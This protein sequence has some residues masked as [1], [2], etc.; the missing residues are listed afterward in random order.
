MMGL[1]SLNM[2]LAYVL[3]GKTKKYHLVGYTITY[4]F[5]GVFKKHF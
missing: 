1:V 4:S 3:K 2:R 5:T